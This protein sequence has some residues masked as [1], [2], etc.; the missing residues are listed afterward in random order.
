MV[1]L[2]RN[3]FAAIISFF[4]H[5]TEGTHSATLLRSRWFGFPPIRH[6]EIYLVSNYRK[7]GN[8][9]CLDKSY[10][11]PHGEKGWEEHGIR[12]VILEKLE[13]QLFNCLLSSRSGLML[14]IGWGWKGNWR[15]CWGCQLSEIL[16]FT[17]ITILNCQDWLWKAKIWRTISEDW[18]LAA[19]DL[20]VIHYEQ[21]VVNDNLSFSSREEW[22]VDKNDYTQMRLSFY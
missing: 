5:S 14:M 7:P 17:W 9:N 11:S 3:P 1:L 15:Y 4:R 10:Q 16:S 18:I 13:A 8:L 19:K 20:M 12:E 22:P 21:V 6:T 2:L